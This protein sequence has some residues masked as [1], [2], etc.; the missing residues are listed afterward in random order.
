MSIQQVQIRNIL[1]LIVQSYLSS[2]INPTDD[3]IHRHLSA[4]FS[5]NP[6]GNP[7]LLKRGIFSEKAQSDEDILND[8][9]A[10]VIYNLDV[11]YETSLDQV[12]QNLMLNSLL[13]TH[14][15]RLKV[16]RKVLE[17][18]LDDFLL[19]IY[20][21][22]GYF[23]STSD[24]F[25]NTLFTDLNLT[26]LFID[27][28]AGIATLPPIPSLSRTIDN[29]IIATANVS[30]VDQNSRSIDVNAK[31]SWINAIDGL[32][33]TAWYVEAMS[34]SNK[35]IA[36]ITIPMSGSNVKISK[37]DITPFG[38]KPV[39]C[40]VSVRKINSDGTIGVTEPFSS[41]VIMSSDKMVFMST[42]PD[43]EIDQ[44]IIQ[45]IKLEHDY[46]VTDSSSNS[47]VFIFGIK[48]LAVIEQYYEPFGTL[49]TKPFGIP[50]VLKNDAVIDAVSIVTNDSV[51]VNTSI[52]Y[53]IAE[54]NPN[55]S[56]LGDFSWKEIEPISGLN[57]AGNSVIRFNGANSFSPMVRKIQRDSSDIVMIPEGTYNPRQ[58]YIPGV[59]TYRICN[60]K[61]AVLS[62]TLKL[63][64]GLNTTRIYYIDRDP[65][66]LS[67]GFLFWNDIINST[68]P[69][70]NIEYGE[71]D[72]GHGF[73]W[74]GDI[75]EKNRSVY[76]E[77]F[78][79][80]DSEM[81]VF[82]KQCRKSDEKSKLWDLKLF[83]NGREIANMPSGVDTLN[84]PWKF[85]KGKNHIVLILDIP[86]LTNS[87]AGSFEIMVGD[88]LTSY[89]NVKLDDWIFVDYYHLANNNTNDA[90][91]FTIYNDEIISR[92][93]PTNNFRLSY[94]KSTSA[95]PEMIRLR[96][97]LSSSNNNT[98]SSPYL[99]SYRVRF[100]YS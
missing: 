47:D 48:E 78:L 50:D 99:D 54:D 77:T 2:G 27:V 100:S 82:L 74:G 36:T 51:P 40:A 5:E 3:D 25:S 94:N 38:V 10:S 92:R 96:A 32:T 79:H 98:N 39:Q 22:D 93:K 88:K 19:G 16:Q 49:V 29:K 97:D 64:E 41:S 71:I 7:V 61:E 84:V 18:R 72:T 58:D 33:N 90:K 11:L 24:D 80:C 66:S 89:G 17:G 95:G 53:F 37:I 76:V 6:V 67:G 46:K 69:S 56:S 65:D 68:N 91:V 9:M 60:F 87:Y 30:V 75:A 15:D 57:T 70:F 86:D 83:L 28:D 4:F 13:I 14:L 31:S 21:S 44:I 81:D 63:E 1:D 12:D 45:M 8:F 26:S 59:N 23:Y 43:R 34:S 55:G 62:N 20:N 85:R 73:F 42:D 35:A 52:K